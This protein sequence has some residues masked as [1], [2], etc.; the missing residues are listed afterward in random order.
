ML[1]CLSFLTFFISP[2]LVES[3]LSLTLTVVLG[4]NVYQIVHYMR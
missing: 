1:V 4:L 2:D 3:R